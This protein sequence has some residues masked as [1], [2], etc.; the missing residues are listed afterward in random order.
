MKIFLIVLFCVFE[1]I[2]W[3]IVHLT[4]E[5]KYLWCKGNCLKC[6]NWKCKYFDKKSKHNS[7]SFGKEE[8]KGCV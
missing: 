2:A 1:L 8:K 5:F 7:L 4:C 3:I 6:Y